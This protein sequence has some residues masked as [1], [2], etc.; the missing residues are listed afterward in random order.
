MLDRLLA[1]CTDGVECYRHA[2]A[3]VQEPSIHRFLARSAAEREEIATVLT[4]TLVSI[5]Y[6]PSHDRSVPGALHR[7]WLDVLGALKHNATPAILHECERG[8]HE[9]IAGFMTVLGRSLPNDV[10]VVVQSQLGRV[11]ET[12]A[13]LRRVVLELEGEPS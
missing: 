1:L 5:G 13:A 7:R 11:L 4:N 2:A 6:K 9:T 3:A 10:H 12:S 8:E